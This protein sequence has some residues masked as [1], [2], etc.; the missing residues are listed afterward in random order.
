[1]H[2]VAPARCK[3]AATPT[4]IGLLEHAARRWAGFPA[5]TLYGGEAWTW[6]YSE[7]WDAARRSAAYLQAAGVG[8]GDRVIIWGNN[9]PEWVTA[10]FG[11]LLLG[12]VVVPLDVR[13]P[14]DM[15]REI[16]AQTRPKH[17][18]LG[19]EQAESLEEA[20]L[21]E[22]PFTSSGQALSNHMLTVLET[23]RERIASLP[24]LEFED[25]AV[26]PDMIAEIVFTSG[27]TGNP[28]G[29]VL[30]HNNIASNA[31]AG[32]V[33][34]DP[35]PAYRVLS[36]LPLSHM[37]EQTCG[38]ILPLSGGASIVYVSTLR[39]DLIF[40][41][42]AR[43]RTTL[44]I[45]VPQ[46][47]ELFR[48]GIEREVRRQGRAKQFERLHALAR[49]LP[50]AV[51]RRLFHQLHARMGSSF[52]IFVSG[53]AYLDADLARWWEGLGIKVVQGY[54][55]TEASP[56]IAANTP[57]DRDQTS[58][59][60]P[61]PGIDVR[62]AED[63]EVMV[64]GDN[65]TAGYWQNPEATAGAFDD[66]WYKTGDLGFLDKAGRLHLHGRK[67]NLIVLA[68]GMNV[69]PEDIEHVL[70]AD[71]RV[72]DAVV[73]GMSR[74]QDVEVHAVL[75]LE[76]GDA[77]AGI[78]RAANARL[79]PHQQI[80]RYTIWPDETFPLTPTLKPKRAE[81]AERLVALQAGRSGA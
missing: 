40:E 33:V 50:L 22:S 15:L 44:M 12:A 25:Q 79:A 28:K 45:G 63:G 17:I 43:Y 30:S 60:R 73:L 55:T 18:V 80:R 8:R 38:M 26:T 9:R 61:L 37:L 21:M 1:M 71:D 65:V 3:G 67:K 32:R 69:Y 34:I 78:V 4:L 58:V 20:P 81:I 29:V 6:S 2:P 48:S 5:V 23:L 24:A 7:L 31:T 11:T 35:T 59:G 76:D 14:R 62:I 16:A 54:G 46:V 66:G 74:G 41:A 70:L 64:R 10:F 39:P 36:I 49:H 72:K 52:D 13:S 68:N 51:R 42:M 19:Q 27:T 75:L 47:L 53:G 57:A 56:V 77:A